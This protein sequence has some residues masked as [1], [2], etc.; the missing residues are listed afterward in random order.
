V[1]FCRRGLSQDC[2]LLASYLYDVFDRV[3]NTELT[4]MI[5]LEDDHHL[6]EER[7]VLDESE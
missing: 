3:L 6:M 1:S 5:L 7:L 4:K 2:K